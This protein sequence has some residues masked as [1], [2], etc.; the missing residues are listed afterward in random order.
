MTVKVIP[1]KEF[2]TLFYKIY[3]PKFIIDHRKAH[4]KQRMATGK[5]QWLSSFWSDF[6]TIIT[7]STSAF[8]A[9]TF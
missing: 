1:L 8:V 7:I 2:D 6:D 3:Q 4:N 5:W 9:E